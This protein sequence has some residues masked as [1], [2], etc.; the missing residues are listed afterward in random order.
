[1]LTTKKAA[2]RAEG[3]NLPLVWII[4]VLAAGGRAPLCCLLSRAPGPRLLL[5]HNLVRMRAAQGVPEARQHTY[6]S[7]SPR[8]GAG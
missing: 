4:A 2:W 5:W 7:E 8:P 3:R 6:Q 1:M